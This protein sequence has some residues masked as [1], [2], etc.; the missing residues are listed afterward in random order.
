MGLSLFAVG[1]LLAHGAAMMAGTASLA[2]RTL[3]DH[4]LPWHVALSLI[5][6]LP[7][8][9]LFR[10]RTRSPFPETYQGV[11]EALTDGVVLLD[12][13]GV[14]V[15][16]NPAALSTLNLDHAELIGRRLGEAV[17]ETPLGQAL[18]AV[19][20][21]EGS[22]EQHVHSGE[23]AV[24][25]RAVPL[26]AAPGG[27]LIILHDAT[28]EVAARLERESL[29]RQVRS[30]RERLG[31]LLRNTSDAIIVL[32]TYGRVRLGNRPAQQLLA[33]ERAERLPPVLHAVIERARQ[34]N[35]PQQAE[36]KLDEQIYLVSATPLTGEGES[37]GIV[38]T[39]R[40]GC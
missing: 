5:G 8:V 38:V 33:V 40:D 10:Q 16:A 12:S 11:L 19:C 23:Q 35:R 4:P 29:L 34:E 20:E 13:A 14:V 31:L 27:R 28:D 2:A 30:E 15:E 18:L 26:P 3:G 17:P 24:S 22:H 7:A 1:S 36:L 21:G 25:V 6:L 9:G 32:D 39:L 37:S